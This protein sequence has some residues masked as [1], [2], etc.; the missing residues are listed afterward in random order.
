MSVYW[1]VWACV[2]GCVRACVRVR[3]CVWCVDVYISV[4]HELISHVTNVQEIAGTRHFWRCWC[5][6][7][8]NTIQRVFMNQACHISMNRDT[9][10]LCMYRK[11]RQL[12]RI[13]RCR[14][15]T[16]SLDRLWVLTAV[17]LL[18]AFIKLLYSELSSNSKEFPPFSYHDTLTVGVTG[19][20]QLVWLGK[21]LTG[22]KCCR[23]AWL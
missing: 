23:P 11:W 22:L 1:W 21:L 9:F 20:S 17:I 8:L 6:N 10:L 19:R 15:P 5:L 12:F 13:W 2:R 3:V 16:T 7:N 18:T 4:Y 14:H